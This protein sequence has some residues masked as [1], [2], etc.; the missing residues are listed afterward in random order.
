MT[1]LSDDDF[2]SEVFDCL[3][4]LFELIIVGKNLVSPDPY[5]AHFSLFMKG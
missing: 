5:G 4:Q 3:D 1:G 2:D